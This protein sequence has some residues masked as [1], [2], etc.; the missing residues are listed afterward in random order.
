MADTPVPLPEPWHIFTGGVYAYL[1]DQL[2]AY[3]DARAKEAEAERDALAAEVDRLRIAVRKTLT[4]MVTNG[5]GEWHE[6]KTLR[7]A[8]P[9]E[10]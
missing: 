4:R 8:L 1:A 2:R 7:A 6:A 9:K 5:M 3:G 10:S